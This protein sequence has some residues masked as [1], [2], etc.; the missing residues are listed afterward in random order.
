MILPLL[1]T[2]TVVSISNEGWKKRGDQLREKKKGRS[3]D[4]REEIDRWKEDEKILREKLSLFK[5][6]KKFRDRII[7]FSN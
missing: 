1:E 5:L 4:N 7:R 6:K 2:K 3:F